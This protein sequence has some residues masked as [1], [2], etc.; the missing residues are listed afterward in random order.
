MKY[1]IRSSAAN[2]YV[3]NTTNWVSSGWVVDINE[4]KIFNSLEEAAAGLQEIVD[5]FN[6]MYWPTNALGIYEVQEVKTLSLGEKITVDTK[7][8]VL[9]IL[10]AISNHGG[11][12][13]ADV[14]DMERVINYVK[15]K[16]T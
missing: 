13:D 11:L 1:V 2:T 15:A 12:R 14:R 4:A 7:K 5:Y 6:D 16:G 10:K 9:Y 8:D 3:K